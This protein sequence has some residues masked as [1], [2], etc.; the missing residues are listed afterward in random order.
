RRGD[1]GSAGAGSADPVHR[2]G[3]RAGRSGGIRPDEVCGQIIG[4]MI[5]LDTQ[6]QFLK[7]VGPRRAEALARLGVRTVEDL[8]YHTPHRYLDATSVTPAAKARVGS[9][10]TLVE[11]VIS[12]GIIPTR[13]RLRIF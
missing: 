12:T 5:R 11:R 7:G 2:G 1:F 4:G 13:K 8:L 10:V 6:V 3:R 9:D